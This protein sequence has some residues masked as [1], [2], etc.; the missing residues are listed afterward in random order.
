DRT[1]RLRN[2]NTTWREDQ[3]AFAANQ[4]QVRRVAIT[5]ATAPRDKLVYPVPANRSFFLPGPP[6]KTTPREDFCE[7]LLDALAL[8]IGDYFEKTGA[9]KTIGV[10]LSGGRDSLLCLYI[11]RRWI[12]RRYGADAKTKAREILRAFFMPSRYSSK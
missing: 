8:G 4:P 1:R 6:P 3:E 2:E 10:A 11:A 12:D 9:F 5:G 7:D